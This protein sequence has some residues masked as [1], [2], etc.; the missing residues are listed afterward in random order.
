MTEFKLRGYQHQWIE[1][2]FEARRNGHHR[3]LL[4]AVG[5]SGKTS[6]AGALSKIEWE[7]HNGR[8]LILENRKQLVEQT[9]K[10]YHDETGMD[11]DIEMAG[12]YASPYAPVVVASVASIGIRGRLK[13]FA[14]TH[15]SIV[16]ADE[17]HN[18]TASL[19]LR[20]MRYFHYGAESLED[21]WEAP[22]DGTYKPKCT[23]IG[24]TAT[25]DTHG[26]RNLGNFYPKF[27]DR[28]SYL[29]AIEDGWLVGIKEV[30]IPVKI[31]T[32]KFRKKAGEHGMDFSPED[33]SAA[34][35]PI[36]EELAKQIIK[37]AHDRKTMCFLPSKECVMVMNTTLNRLGLKSTF[38]LGDCLDRGEKTDEFQAHGNGICLCLCAMYVEGTDFPS[39]NCVAWMRPTLSP[40]FYKQGVYRM[41]R[42]LPGVVNDNMTPNER[43]AA[44]AASD[45][46]HGLLISP[47]F[48]SD[49]VDIMS[50]VDLFVDPALKGTKRAPSDFTDAAKIRDFIKQLE[51]A[52][53]KH[54]H[55][56]P[57]TIDPVKFSLSVE[58]SSLANYTPENDADAKP[59]S[60]DELDF[61]LAQNIDTSAVKS[62]G[63]AQK[64]IGR[65]RERERLGLASPRQL[66]QLMFR[67]HW[68]EE[69]AVTF[70]KGRAGITIAH[71]IE[72]KSYNKPATVIAEDW[73]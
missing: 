20:T 27:V 35:I 2:T 14:D 32:R 57:R 65:L 58:G 47:F 61:L 30:N 11:V 37:L 31:D 45:K 10:R 8:T 26:K 68:P 62:S 22:K 1:R 51:K 49:K 44:I 23:V 41:S 73:S 16:F 4:D 28:Y 21:G 71:H 63:Q 48:I 24:I 17:A 34:I 13:A 50:V 42:V 67:F 12:H 69:V 72:Y 29:Q 60:K 39:V 15:F 18:S 7:A 59:A 54:A 46:T 9:A 3:L 36:I 38:V 70:K 6:Y 33:E 40:S 56:Q 19:F 5:G 55:K 53:D 52:A 43:R 25:P 64:L 66:Q